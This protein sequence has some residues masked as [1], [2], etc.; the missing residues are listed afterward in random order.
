MSVTVI[1]GPVAPLNALAS[2][3]LSKH[4][5]YLSQ[6]SEEHKIINQK[7]KKTVAYVEKKVLKFRIHSVCKL[8]TSID[9]PSGK[10]SVFSYDQTI[11][12]TRSPMPDSEE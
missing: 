7:G 8:E 10:L 11:G 9:S 1:Q 5:V 3:R 6:M 12:S 4:S 2:Q